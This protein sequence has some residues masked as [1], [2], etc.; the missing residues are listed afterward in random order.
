MGNKREYMK[1]RQSATDKNTVSCLSAVKIVALIPRQTFLSFN[2]SINRHPLTTNSSLLNPSSLISHPRATGNTANPFLLLALLLTLSLSSGISA[3]TTPLRPADYREHNLWLN[4]T[5]P[6]GLLFNP[7]TPSSLAEARYHFTNG[8]LHTANQAP[9]IQ[10]YDL[11]S[12]SYRHLKK[13]QLYGKIGYQN[14]RQ[15]KRQWAT[16]INPENHLINFGD[17]IPGRQTIENYTISGAIA[18]PLHHHWS[19]GGKINY[20]ARS[21]TK[22]TDPRNKNIQTDLSAAPGI[23]Y[24]RPFLNIGANFI[25][26]RIAE[27]ITY[28]LL[29]TELRDGK[30]F[31][32]LWF[33]IPE[34]FQNGLNNIRKYEANNYGGAI[35]LSVRSQKLEILNEFLYLKGK[36]KSHTQL[37]AK[38]GETEHQE[39]VYKSQIRI[40]GKTQQTFTPFYRHLIR[41]GF[42]NLQGKADN[43]NQQNQEDYGRVKRAAI[44]TDQA[45]LSYLLLSSADSLSTHYKIKARF[46]YEHE[47]TLFFI[48][49]A[50]FSQTVDHYSFSVGYDHFRRF[51]NHSF[52]IATQA[53]YAQGHGQLPTLHPADGHPTPEISMSQNTGLLIRDLQ[54][55]TAKTLQLLLDIQYT[56]YLNQ[57]YALFGRTSADYRQALSQPHS[58]RLHT[59]I[60]AGLLF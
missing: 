1:N 57:S 45:G 16:A 12:E 39:F 27:E 42:D 51:R 33:S 29:N 30:T 18:F 46:D 44:T 24:S 9:S 7:V 26:H 47:Q 17:T 49:P 23:L 20:N 13:I 50:H 43:S 4:T 35:Q 21:A 53:G 14:I 3:Q 41:T 15:N 10:Q 36:E 28:S 48:Y 52:Q 58:Y 6:A 5:N 40:I 31:Y 8:G 22:N 25:Y 37:H 32:P 38:K 34:N 60:S 2:I 54:V 56:R 19:A 59:T 11:Y 55:K